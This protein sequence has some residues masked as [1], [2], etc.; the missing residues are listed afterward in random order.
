MKVFVERFADDVGDGAVVV[1]CGLLK[2]GSEGLC[3]TAV[4]VEVGG[5]GHLQF[6]CESIA[7]YIAL[8]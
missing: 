6:L 1:F 3:D 7:S 8:F 4:N 2:T 5:F